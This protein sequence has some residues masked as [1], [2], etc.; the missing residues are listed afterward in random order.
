MYDDALINNAFLC[1]GSFLSFFDEIDIRLSTS[2]RL[3]IKEL[4]VRLEREREENS[5]IIPTIEF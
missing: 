4:D 1:Y 3:C 2:N 5:L